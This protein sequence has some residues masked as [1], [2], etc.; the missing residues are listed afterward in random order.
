MPRV[1]LTRSARKG[2]LSVSGRIGR[3]LDDALAALEMGLV[4]GEPLRGGLKHLFRLRVEYHRIIYE[5]RSDG[6]IRVLRI[7]HRS[8]AY[9]SDP[10]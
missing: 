10:R 3:E 9:R 1:V 5:V 6:T 8:V 4:T 2:R 7:A